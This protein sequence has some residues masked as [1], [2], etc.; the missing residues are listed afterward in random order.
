MDRMARRAAPSR[1]SWKAMVMRCVGVTAIGHS[2]STSRRIESRRCPSRLVSM[3][4]WL[5]SPSPWAAWP[6]PTL[7]RA[8]SMA[9]GSRSR[10]PGSSSL[11]SM[12]PPCRFGGRLSR[13]PPR[14]RRRNPELA[15]ER[16]RLDSDPWRNLGKA[17]GKIDRDDGG[18]EPGLFPGE[19]P[20]HRAHHIVAVGL[21]QPDLDNV[22]LEHVSGLR[23]L[24]GDG[25]GQ[26]VRTG[27]TLG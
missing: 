21:G 11:L 8:L 5:T 2:S 12:F 22:D 7:N 9:T 3:A 18:L 26:H 14:R 6:S 13:R 19:H 15:E 1:S 23:T 4:V 25:A 17:G 16:P 24:H 10:V 20:L 27:A